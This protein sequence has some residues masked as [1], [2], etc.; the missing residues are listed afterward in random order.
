MGLSFLLLHVA[1]YPIGLLALSSTDLLEGGA[2][3]MFDRGG[4]ENEFVN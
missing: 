2:K 3:N 4:H 1:Q